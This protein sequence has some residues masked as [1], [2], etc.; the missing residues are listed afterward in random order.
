[1]REKEA[2]TKYT[3]FNVDND[4]D[5][6]PIIPFD[7]TIPE[8]DIGEPLPPPAYKYS[9]LTDIKASEACEVHEKMIWIISFINAGNISNI[10]V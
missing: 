9:T 3:G 10:I 4:G 6:P 7:N 5:P 1:M 2:E 8:P